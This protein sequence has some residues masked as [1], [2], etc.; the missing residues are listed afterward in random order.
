MAELQS[1]VSRAVPTANELTGGLRRILSDMMAAKLAGKD[2]N[3]DELA[4]EGAALLMEMRRLEGEI[5]QGA[6]PSIRQGALK[7]EGVDDADATLRA[8]R[9]EKARVLRGIAECRRAIPA[10]EVE[11]GALLD[12]AAAAADDHRGKLARLAAE[13]HER[14]NLCDTLGK[15]QAR[16]RARDESTDSQKVCACH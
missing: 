15:E 13:C 11:E 12:V 9:Y 5:C 2:Q 10:E 4:G 3:R 6:L 16:K 14:R 1:A 7:Q 8:L